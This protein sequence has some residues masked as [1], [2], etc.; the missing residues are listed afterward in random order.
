MAATLIGGCVGGIVEQAF[1]H[2]G[3]GAMAAG[4][5]VGGA[6]GGFGYGLGKGAMALRGMT[7]GG[8]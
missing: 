5:V 4:C 3:A 7:G 8:G 6:I 1:A 2:E